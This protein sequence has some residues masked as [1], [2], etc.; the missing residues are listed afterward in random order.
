M[1]KEGV[2]QHNFFDTGMEGSAVE[3]EH[4]PQSLRH[5]QGPAEPDELMQC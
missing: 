1:K 2:T 3:K 4:M 5:Q